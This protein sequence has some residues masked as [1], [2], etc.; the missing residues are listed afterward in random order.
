[1][2]TSM[3]SFADD[4]DGEGEGCGNNNW[5]KVVLHILVFAVLFVSSGPSSGGSIFCGET[6]RRHLFEKRSA[7]HNDAKLS[8]KSARGN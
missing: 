8:G 3:R 2:A 4:V 6:K 5:N 7:K 1:M